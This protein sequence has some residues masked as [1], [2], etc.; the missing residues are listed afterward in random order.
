M[1][2][3]IAE[4]HNKFWNIFAAVGVPKIVDKILYLYPTD[5]QGYIIPLR[6]LITFQYL[7]SCGYS[8]VSMFSNPTEIL[9]NDEQRIPLNKTY[10]MLCN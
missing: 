5:A 4:V 3:I 1:P 9:F 10:F 6:Y 2:S 7:P 8:F